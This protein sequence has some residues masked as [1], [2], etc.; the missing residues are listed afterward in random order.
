MKMRYKDKPGNIKLPT[1]KRVLIDDNAL[2]I[3]A[4][5]KTELLK[6]GISH[7]NWSDAIRELDRRG[8]RNE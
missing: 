5:V 7:V 3:L 6:S 8:N 4:R 1:S 2:N